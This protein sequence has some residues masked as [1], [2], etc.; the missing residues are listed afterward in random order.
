MSPGDPAPSVPPTKPLGEHA[1]IFKSTAVLGA[2]RAVT[3]V[4]G[5]LRV[6]A[7]A[8]LLG[9]PGVG[10]FGTFEV[11]LTAALYIAGLG[12]SSAG[13]REVALARATGPEAVGDALATLW[14]LCAILGVAGAV[15][16]ALLAEPLARLTFGD[17]AR[18]AAVLAFAPAVLFANLHAAFRSGLQGLQRIPALATAT[19]IQACVDALLAVA[20]ILWLGESGVAP[21]IVLGAVAGAS[22]M[23]L[24][25]RRN[26]EARARPP[27]GGFPARAQP[28]ILLGIGMSAAFLI[29]TLV[30]Y[31]VRT[32][33]VRD[34]GL[35]AAGIYVAAFSLSGK[36]ISFMLDA[37]QLDF[38]PRLSASARDRVQMNSLLNQQSEIL[39]LL[40]GPGL[41]ATLAAAPLLVTVFYAAE[42]APAKELLRWFAFGA[43]FRLL[44]APMAF[45]LLAQ[46]RSL[47]YFLGEL[48]FGVSQLLLVLGGLAWLGVE[49]AAIGYAAHCIVQL[50]GLLAIARYA[51]GFSWNDPMRRLLLVFIPGALG[52]FL[53]TRILPELPMLGIGI[54]ASCIAFMW[55]MR[56]LVRLLGSKHRL[57]R[58][59]V[60]IP[61]LNHLLK[62]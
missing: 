50:T 3:L 19:I 46:G 33:I 53:L 52:A 34:F 1:S 62:A 15:V 18:A 48:V 41:L 47:L 55:C 54:V 35:G 39:L 8:L 10:L 51:T 31:A 43:L 7:V 29:S 49:G 57:T 61:L 6:K 36:F 37:T 11:L 60:R 27:W 58:A 59:L 25:L 42:F 26:P 17:P 28:F 40:A 2:A 56:C 12:V 4:I 9:P 32:T 44:Y 22:I 23:F 45:I 21:A 5:L 38:Y 24:T 13:V 20:L 14:R 16:L 30:A